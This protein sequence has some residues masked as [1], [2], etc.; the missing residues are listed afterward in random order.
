MSH[1]QLDEENDIRFDSIEVNETYYMLGD[2]L[3]PHCDLEIK[4]IYPGDYSDKSI[5]QTLQKRFTADFFGE[6]YAHETAPDAANHYVRKYIA[7][8][9]ELEKNFEEEMAKDSGITFWGYNYYES[10]HNEILYNRHDI[11]SYCII[12]DCYTGGAHGSHGYI[13]HVAD[14]KSGNILEEE[15]I[16]VDEYQEPLAKIIINTLMS[17][18]GI[19]A[20]EELE[21]KGFFNVK[22][23]VPNNNFYIDDKGITYT[24]NEYE[25]APYSVGSISVKI[26]YDKIRKLLQADSP[27]MRIKS[28]K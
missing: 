13:Y 6:K 4:Y 14:L 21:E 10:T 15:D 24:Y 26:P 19:T 25:I 2:S 23:I 5:L 9:R 28:M 12:T 1:H 17:D 7:D 11:I 27:V 18:Y 22:E 3:N 20:E 8:Y 16:F